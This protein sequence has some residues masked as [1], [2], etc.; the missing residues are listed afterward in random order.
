[1]KANRTAATIVVIGS[2]AATL[3]PTLAVEIASSSFESAGEQGPANWT[4]VGAATW[5][6]GVAAEGR[7]FMTVGRGGAWVSQ[8]VRFEPGVA[9]ELRFRLR[10]RPEEDT[11]GVAFVGPEFAP[12]S[13]T[14]DASPAKTAWKTETIRFMAPTHPDMATCPVRLGEWQLDGLLDY[15]DLQLRPLQIVHQTVS[16]VALGAGEQI[17]GS[18]YTFEAPLGTWRNLCRPLQNV[19][20]R[21]HDNRWHFSREGSQ[22][23]Y[24]HEIAGAEQQS[25]TLT[26][27]TWFAWPSTLRLYVEASTDGTAYREIATVSDDGN[28][29]YDR[30][31]TVPLPRSLFPAQ[32]VWIRLRSEST[33][34]AQASTIQC[35]RYAYS[36]ELGGEPRP[37]SGSTTAWTVLGREAN[38]E[39]AVKAFSEQ[40]PVL[41][42]VVRNRSPRT[43]NLA[44]SIVVQCDD[45]SPERFAAVPIE[46]APGVQSAVS[47]PFAIRSAN[48]HTIGLRLGPSL[49][50]H[51]ATE[52]HVPVLHLSGYGQSL[53]SPDPLIGLWWASSGWKVSRTRPAP[54]ETGNTV[55]VRL[56]RNEVEAVQLAVRPTR[57]LTGLTLAVGDLQTSAGDI[58]SSEAVELLQ[59]RYVPVEIAS[60]HFGCIDEWPD[61]LPLLGDSIA[62]AADQNQPLWLRVTTPRDARPGVYRGTIS[63][64]A[65]GF[66]AE[67]PLAVEAYDFTLPDTATCR[68]L[69]GFSPSTVFRYHR[70]TS[71]ADKR[72][73]LDKYLRSFSR[74]RISPYDPAPLDRFTCQWPRESEWDG[75][76]RLAVGDAHSGSKSLCIEDATTTGSPQTVYRHSLALSGRPLKI[77]LWYKTAE[78]SPPAYI[79][80]SFL[81]RDGNHLA[82]RNLHCELLGSQTW[83][84]FEHTVARYP[85]GAHTA[86]LSI[87]GAPWSEKGEAVGSVWVDDVSVTDVDSGDEFIR[88]G[89]FESAQPLSEAVAAGVKFDWSAWDAAMERA[90]NDYHFNSFVFGVPGLGGGTFYE[91]YDGSLNGFAAGTPEYLALFRAWCEAARSHLAEKGWLDKAVTP[92]PLVWRFN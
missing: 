71:E 42:A 87:Q 56:A 90:F 62:V 43:L 41:R 28:R 34:D 63:V 80:V 19:E 74:H 92:V 11:G 14:L 8:P 33:A 5:G 30:F 65:D 38:L 48:R 64:R 58:L 1:M 54:E 52:I 27:G 13:V 32:T 86:M 23:V 53:P 55:A 67:I 18:R 85:D 47:I 7:R 31:V 78:A 61:P 45:G 24:R 46:L 50:T 59:V 77:N 49:Q 10:Y 69:L 57:P 17:R 4:G 84:A 66:K 79:Y 73:V 25:A 40:D 12:Q 60:D 35:P 22:L 75:T 15:D 20:T 16:G 44:P 2:F 81:D 70:V 51:L 3:S 91:R 88:D 37:L 89:G 82:G 29:S 72:T 6:E 39:V 9:Y 26:L 21:F 83:R 76:A 36:A 68:S